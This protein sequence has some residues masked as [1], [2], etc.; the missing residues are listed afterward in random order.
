M[1]NSELIVDNDGNLFAKDKN[2]KDA[3][4]VIK[5]IMD[6]LHEQFIEMSL[7]SEEA[8]K[9]DF[10]E[11]FVAFKDKSKDINGIEKGL[12]RKIGDAYKVA[13]DYYSKE[14]ANALGKDFKTKNRE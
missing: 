10:G 1:Q 7:L 8:K 6:N 9:I 3:Y 14:F 13:G 11:Y 5:P 12:R 4:L 2:I